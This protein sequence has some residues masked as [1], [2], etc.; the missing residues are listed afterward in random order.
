VSFELSVGYH[1]MARPHG[2]RRIDLDH[3][4]SGNGT[5]LRRKL[6]VRGSRTWASRN[7]SSSLGRRRRKD[8]SRASTGSCAT[9]C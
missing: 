2:R 1:F 3:L 4:H 9:N 6:C 5:G 7:C 8:T